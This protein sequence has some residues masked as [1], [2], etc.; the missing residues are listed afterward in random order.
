MASGRQPVDVLVEAAGDLDPSARGRALAL[1]IRHSDE[2]AG[3]SWAPRALYDPNPWVAQLAIEAVHARAPESAA[4][5][6]LEATAARADL[7][8]YTRGAAAVRAAWEGSDLV[9]E[10]MRSAWRGAEPW[11]R[12]PLALAGAVLG[13]E[14]AVQ[15]LADALAAGDLPLELRFFDDLG[16]SGLTA[17]TPALAT[18]AGRVEPE[19]HMAIAAALLEL[20]A[21]Q[22]ESLMREAL[23]SSDL[24][25]RLEA[26][27]FL[28]H[29]DLPAADALLVRAARGATLDARYAELALVAR[30]LAPTEVAIESSQ[31]LDR[32][33]RRLAVWALGQAPPARNERAARPA[34]EALAAALDDAEYAVVLEAV[35]AIAAR[36]RSNDRALVEPLLAGEVVVLRVEAAA[37][38][39]ALPTGG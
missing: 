15:V 12:P 13:D 9:L 14:E 16:A 4:L 19:L 39:L 38:L 2:P 21:S 22:G 1:L 20:G 27:D 31:S 32:E 23:S 7:D 6:L 29:V 28:V 35:Q 5:E 24:E 11:D 3:G 26:L 25:E 37:A 10:P 30:G 18:C 34:R 33:L 36:G 17:V 8:A